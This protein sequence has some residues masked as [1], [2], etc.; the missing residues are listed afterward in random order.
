M[1]YSFYFI[2]LTMLTHLPATSTTT[3][4]DK[5]EQAHLVKLRDVL[6]LHLAC[7]LPQNVPLRVYTCP[8]HFWPEI[9]QTFV[10]AMDALS[11]WMKQKLGGDIWVYMARAQG[12]K[13]TGYKVETLAGVEEEAKAWMLLNRYLKFNENDA[14]LAYECLAATLGSLTD[15]DLGQVSRLPYG[16]DSDRFDEINELVNDPKKA[17]LLD[18]L[19]RA[20]RDHFEMSRMLKLLTEWLSRETYQDAF[21]SR[22]FNAAFDNNLKIIPVEQLRLKT[23]TAPDFERDPE[24]VK[25]FEL[26]LRGDFS[27]QLESGILP[28]KSVLSFPGRDYIHD[29]VARIREDTE[30]NKICRSV[31]VDIMILFNK[32]SKW[33]DTQLLFNKCVMKGMSQLPDSFFEDYL[34]LDNMEHFYLELMLKKAS[35]P[36]FDKEYY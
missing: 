29:F 14:A 18:G 7:P 34:A 24:L 15:I 10:P 2:L 30:D 27:T 23:V 5:L 25:L 20:A 21:K 9:L 26:L 35:L 17:R 33:D 6:K 36:Y 19:K 4:P 8:S 13:I 28:K 22:I 31:I 12:P 3:N 32:Q 11:A 1:L 16:G